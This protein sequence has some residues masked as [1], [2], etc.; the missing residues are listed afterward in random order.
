MG[1]SDLGSSIEAF[2]SWLGCIKLAVKTDRDDGLVTAVCH[3]GVGTPALEGSLP[4]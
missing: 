2:L 4:G 1:Q 3:T